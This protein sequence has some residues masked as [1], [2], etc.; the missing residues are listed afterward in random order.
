MIAPIENYDSRL[1]MAIRD[2]Y[3]AMVKAGIIPKT[4]KRK[5]ILNS[6][7]AA[8]DVISRLP[9]EFRDIDTNK[10]RR[11]CDVL[12]KKSAKD[13]GFTHLREK[14]SRSSVDRVCDV[15]KKWSESREHLHS[16]EYERESQ[17]RADWRSRVKSRERYQCACCGEFRVSELLQIHHYHYRNLGQEHPD[18]VCC[19]CSPETGM[20]CHMMLDFSREL[21]DGK[22]E[23][24][25]IRSLF[26]L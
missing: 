21:R 7:E 6:D 8:M 9:V 20:P 22:V 11:I 3:E 15:L 2:T 14:N 23:P 24:E 25:E 4:W 26:D 10:F 1:T 16:E 5:D 13:G 18:D 19:V 12:D 17:E